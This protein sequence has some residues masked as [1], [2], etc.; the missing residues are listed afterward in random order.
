VVVVKTS[1]KF[2]N[3][4]RKVKMYKLLHKLFG[5]DYVYWKNSADNGIARVHKA[6][7]GVVYYYR[8]KS[9]QLI[10]KVL[11]KEQVVWLTCPASKYL[12]N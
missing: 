4:L 11:K 5:W 10:D 9:T 12:E 2:K 3:I 7:E 1:Q 8:Y 6:Q